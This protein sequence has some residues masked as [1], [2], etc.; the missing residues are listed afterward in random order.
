MIPTTAGKA[1]LQEILRH[2]DVFLPN[3][4]EACKAAGTDDLEAAIRKLSEL[5]PLVVV[6]LGS[7]GALAQRGAERFER[8]VARSRARRY[9]GSG[10]QLRRRISSPVHSRRRLAHMPGERQSSGSTLRNPPRRHRSISRRGT[11]R[12]FPPPSLGGL[13][14]LFRS[15]GIRRSGPAGAAVPHERFTSRSLPAASDL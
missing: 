14:L 3:E 1:D 9:G 5:V 4:R 10:R 13:K 2:V 15:S 7:K 12:E 6:K 8:P 11:S